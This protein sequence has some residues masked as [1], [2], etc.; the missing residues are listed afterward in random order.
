MEESLQTIL[1]FSLP[2]AWAARA[3]FAYLRGM[4]MFQLNSYKAATHWKWLLKNDEKPLRNLTVLLSVSLAVNL[5]CA[6]LL[7]L[8]DFILYSG[9][10]LLAYFIASIRLPSKKAKKPLV[11]TPRV[12]RMLV[13][14]GLV[15]ALVAAGGYFI[16]PFDW[17]WYFLLTLFL[18]DYL[19]LPANLINMPIEAYIRRWFIKDAQKILRI[20]PDLVTI[21][22]TGSYGKTSVKYYLTEL[23]RGKFQTLMT[24]ESYNTPMGIAKTVR[25][26]LRGFHEIFVCEMGARYVS[27]IHKLC[28]F[29]HPRHGIIT[30]IGEQH[31]E[32]FKSR[33]NILHEKLALARTVTDG[34]LFINGDN[35]KLRQNRPANAIAYGLNA[36]YNDCY[37]YDIAVT[38]RGTTFSVNLRGE[39]LEDLRTTLIGAHNVCNLVG[40]IS[41]ARALDV[42]ESDIRARLKRLSAPP[43]RLALTRTNG[44]AIIDDAYNS[45]PAGAKAALDALALFD[46]YKALITPGMVELGAEQYDANFR[47][48]QQAAAVCDYVIA[49]GEK[50]A[51]PILAGLASKGYHAEQ[52]FTAPSFEAAIAKAYA[53][54][55]SG[56]KIILL[57]NDLPDNY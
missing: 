53:L 8:P 14:G 7:H 44:V 51:P 56:E 29:V 25:G 10:M 31:L 40:A 6:Y 17:F 52:T 33:E 27:D 4:H 20:C 34:L 36:A 43:H 38:V 24:P 28:D 9:S 21:G 45:N 39:L 5:I 11:Y 54:P 1:S 47:F 3:F 41:M 18:V 32:T 37:A 15:L 26:E 46:G 35:D 23:L 30:A 50:Q 13:S 16:A 55:C 49:V 48:G 12:V 2:A 42:P 22:I 19:P 57:E